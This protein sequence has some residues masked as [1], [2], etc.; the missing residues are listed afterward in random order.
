[1]RSA[2]APISSKRRA[3]RPKRSP[4]RRAPMLPLHPHTPCRQR[5]KDSHT[6]NPVSSRSSIV[7]NVLGSRIS[8]IVSIRIRSG[9]SSA[10][11][12]V[13]NSSVSRRSG[14]RFLEIANATAHSP[15]RPA[16]STACRARRTPMRAM[17]IQCC[18]STSREA[19]PD[20]ISG[21]RESTRC[22][23]R[24]RDT[25]SPRS[26]DEPRAPRGARDRAPTSPEI[27]VL[28]RRA[29]ALELV[30]TPRRERQDDRRRSSARGAR[31]PRMYVPWP[32]S[33]P[34]SLDQRSRLAESVGERE[35]GAPG[36]E[37]GITGPNPLPYHL[38]TPHWQEVILPLAAPTSVHTGRASHVVPARLTAAT[39]RSASAACS[40]S[41][42]RPGPRP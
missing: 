4:F 34:S 16:S 31:T 35:A 23:S 15:V 17:S 36:F 2:P 22:P 40:K 12:R 10:S 33:R 27:A 5:R 8:V 39:A 21:P 9:G 7:S 24:S 18:A 3:A 29:M 32:T 1:M 25:P 30:A 14:V 13:S 37:P 19:L 28:G 42:R 6:G 26:F 41:H 11:A 20:P 38:A